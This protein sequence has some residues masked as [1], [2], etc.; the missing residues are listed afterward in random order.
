MSTSTGGDKYKPKYKFD[1]DSYLIGIG[2][3]TS[4]CISNNI[5]QSIMVLTPTP[6]LYLRGITGNLKFKGEGTLVWRIYD[7]QGQSHKIKMKN[8]LYTPSLP[9][10][11]AS[12]QHGADQADDNYP[13]LDETWCATYTTSCVVWWDQRKFTRTIPMKNKSNTPKL[14]STPGTINTY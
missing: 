12:P 9:S 7:D 3:H 13:S 10:C 2:N 8:C 11:L 14:F 6:R 5:N 4:T 1:S